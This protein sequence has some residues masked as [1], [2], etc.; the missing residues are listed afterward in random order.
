M[1]NYFLDIQYIQ[2]IKSWLKSQNL[3]VHL[4]QR[5]H[6]IL[7]RRW[8]G[9][10]KLGDPVLNSIV[11]YF[12]FTKYLD[13]FWHLLGKNAAKLITKKRI[14]NMMGAIGG[15]Y[16]PPFTPP[17]LQQLYFKTFLIKSSFGGSLFDVFLYVFL[18]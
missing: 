13:F 3:H 12:R 1:G 17:I 18:F 16:Y 15:G 6:K 11:L 4:V 9:G 7:V 2:S 10:G 5:I 14:L 8:G